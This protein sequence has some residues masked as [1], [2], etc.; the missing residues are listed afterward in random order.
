MR[1]LPP[2]PVA[3]GSFKI[4]DVAPGTYRL[5]AFHEGRGYWVRLEKVEVDWG[6]SV[7]L[8]MRISATP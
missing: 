6:Q 1:P 8:E 4:R 2:G 5:C 7:S 3:S